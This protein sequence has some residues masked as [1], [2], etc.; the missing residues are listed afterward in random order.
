MLRPKAQTVLGMAN[1]DTGDG[2]RDAYHQN[3]TSHYV[4][5]HLVLIDLCGFTPK[6][7]YMSVLLRSQRSWLS[8][9]CVHILLSCFSNRTL[10]GLLFPG[11]AYQG[12]SKLLRELLEEA[13]RQQSR[14][15]EATHA[16][17]DQEIP[18]QTTG[19]RLLLR[20]SNVVEV[21]RWWCTWLGAFS[22]MIS[23]C[24]GC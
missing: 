22:L 1:G 23:T 14:S 9:L 12:A 19:R 5:S 2:L 16:G 18:Q 13:G 10:N 15:K 7:I 11:S 8:Y 4:V 24:V 3:T 17:L 21:V 6:V 20:R